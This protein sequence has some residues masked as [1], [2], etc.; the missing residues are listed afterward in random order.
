MIPHV[1]AKAHEGLFFMVFNAINI[2]NEIITVNAL[3]N[4]HRNILPPRKSSRRLTVGDSVTDPLMRSQ[5]IILTVS[6]FGQINVSFYK[7]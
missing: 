1:P 3:T 4:V 6:E 5:S 2:P 7:A